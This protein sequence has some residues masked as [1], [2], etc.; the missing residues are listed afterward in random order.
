MSTPT[1][2]F[3]IKSAV[4][5]T[6]DVICSDITAKG[7]DVKVNSDL[8]AV[9]QLYLPGLDRVPGVDSSPE[10]LAWNSISG[11]VQVFGVGSRIAREFNERF[12]YTSANW[13]TVIPIPPSLVWGPIVGAFSQP[14]VPNTVGCIIADT[15][16]WR[17]TGNNLANLFV[18]NSDKNGMLFATV[19]INPIERWVLSR[20]FGAP[21]GAF[22][23]TIRFAIGQLFPTL[24]IY[25]GMVP[26]GDIYLYDGS[27]FGTMNYQFGFA[28]GQTH[29]SNYNI[30][31]VKTVA[32]VYTWVDTGIPVIE[33]QIMTLSL[34]WNADF[35]G[36]IYTYSN[37][38]VMDS[39]VSLGASY[40]SALAE[41]FSPTFGLSKHT[42]EPSEIF[43]KQIHV[44]T[45]SNLAP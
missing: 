29:N 9:A 3:R 4:C 39:N 33:G 15:G 31:L 11:K 37:G 28:V 34:R 36:V 7:L 16:V 25:C 38:T 26:S 45:T 44:S 42:G 2:T 32:G 1:P 43:F 13:S 8:K 20:P 6:T 24:A 40:G 21:G 22:S 19:A 5:S 14:L 12:C 18:M 35:D 27:N 23:Y 17:V 41:Y 30:Q 10:L